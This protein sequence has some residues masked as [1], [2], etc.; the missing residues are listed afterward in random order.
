M[1]AKHDYNPLK[2]AYPIDSI[3]E[4]ETDKYP[5]SSVGKEPKPEAAADVPVV[6]LS[7]D[8]PHR[9]EDL[10]LLHRSQKPAFHQSEG[11][12]GAQ[13]YHGQGYEPASTELES[14]ISWGLLL[15]CS[16]IAFIILLMVG[17]SFFI[18]FM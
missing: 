14:K 17:T 3:P 18:A 13:A 5:D 15:G 6:D 1:H 7:T 11:F 2:T 9:D 16:F 10:A 12:Q 8:D 4:F